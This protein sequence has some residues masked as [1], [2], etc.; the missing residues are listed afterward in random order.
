M[1]ECKLGK[2]DLIILSV[3]C[4]SLRNFPTIILRK[5]F[6]THTHPPISICEFWKPYEL[7]FLE[8]ESFIKLK[9]EL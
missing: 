5:L 3:A 7:L 9:Y 1:V 6:P 8:F 2:I 4:H